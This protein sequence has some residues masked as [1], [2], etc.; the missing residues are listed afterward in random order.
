MTLSRSWL[1]GAL[2]VADEA[3]PA[4]IGGQAVPNLFAGENGE[5]VGGQVELKEGERLSEVRGCWSDDAVQPRAG[6]RPTNAVACRT[7]QPTT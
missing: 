5:F 1:G 3:E 2:V 6:A 7:R 4:R